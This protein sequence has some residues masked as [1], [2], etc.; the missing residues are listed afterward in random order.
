MKIQRNN[1]SSHNDVFEKKTF[2]IKF[3]SFLMKI[4]IIPLYLSSEGKFIY[5]CF[6]WKIVVYI[7]LNTSCICL[8]MYAQMIL[9]GHTVESLSEINE[10]RSSIDTIST[11]IGYSVQ[12]YQMIFP[13]LLFHGFSKLN[14]NA[15]SLKMIKIKLDK[16]K[17]TL[18]KGSNYAIL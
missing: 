10:K 7:F 12:I 16:Y 2:Q 9:S 8:C 1:L 13:L 17:I 4:G 15:I 6:S 14:S 18:G 11:I 5:K 3:V